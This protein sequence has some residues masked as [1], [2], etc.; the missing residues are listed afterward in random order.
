MIFAMENV[1][2]VPVA[3]SRVWWRR[4][5]LRPLVSCLMALGWS[6]VGEKLEVSLNFLLSII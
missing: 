5:F 1:F 6:P 2:P 3:P 4:P